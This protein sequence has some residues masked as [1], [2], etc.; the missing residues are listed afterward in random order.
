MRYFVYLLI[1]SNNNK[2]ITYVGYTSNIKNRIRLHNTSKGAK[3]TRGRQWKLIYKK[4]YNT[5]S[6]AMRNEYLLKKNIKKRSII[7]K[8]FLKNI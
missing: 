1:S 7:K 5:K 8:K 6:S 3:F 2:S 4:A